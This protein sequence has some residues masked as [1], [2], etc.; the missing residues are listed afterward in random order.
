MVAERAIVSFYFG[1][2]HQAKS[3][4]FQKQI[5]QTVTQ[6]PQVAANIDALRK[7]RHDSP[8]VVATTDAA[9]SLRAEETRAKPNMALEEILNR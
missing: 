3:Q 7:L 5:A 8:G 2:R 4:D 1:A 9:A 6:V